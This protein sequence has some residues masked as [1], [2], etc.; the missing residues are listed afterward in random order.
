[1]HSFGRNL[2]EELHGLRRRTGF[3]RPGWRRAALIHLAVL[4]LF[5]VLLPY[6]KGIEFLDAVVLGAYACLGVVFVAPAAAAPFEVALP[7]RA[8]AR[9]I[10]CVAY[11]CAMSWSMLACGLATVYLRSPFFIGLDL[12][13]LGESMLF[14]V[15]LST[16]A[17]AIAAFLALRV[18]AGVAK[19]AMRVVFMVLLMT[20]F[21]YSRRLPD[22]AL[23]G[24]GIAG[25]VAV[26]FMA[27]LAM[28][29]AAAG[30]Q[31]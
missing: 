3:E 17:A 5:G 25:A 31:A 30:P 24:A 9:I 27:L 18:S 14:G 28:P 19:A 1:M 10:V 4:G 23:E 16:A 11:G 29:N 26:A 2:A 13:A 22:V 15:A 12:A 20:F 21:W 6:I 8:L 7:G